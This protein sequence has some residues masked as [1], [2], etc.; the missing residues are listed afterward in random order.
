MFDGWK[1]IGWAPVADSKLAFQQDIRPKYDVLVFYD[2]TRDLDDK[3]KKNLRDFVESGEGILV[4]HH[5]ILNFQKWP[6]WYKEVVGGLYRL[7]R[8]GAI[9]NSTVKLG[10]EH[11][12]TPAGDHPIT[13][14]IGPFHVPTSG[15][16]WQAPARPSARLAEGALPGIA[17]RGE[18]RRHRASRRRR[19][20]RFQQPGP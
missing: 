19:Q 2:F 1:D 4:L 11:M 10:E 3:G 18:R 5:G 8:Q 16:R 7:E 14:S 12:I 20:Q 9:P 15:D 17:A 13:A 6:W